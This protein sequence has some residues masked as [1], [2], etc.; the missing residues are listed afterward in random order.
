MNFKWKIII[1]SLSRNIYFLPKVINARMLDHLLYLIKIRLA[2]I[3]MRF[4][5]YLGDNHGFSRHMS[6]GY[7]YLYQLF[8]GRLCVN[9]YIEFN[10][11]N[12]I[13]ITNN[14]YSDVSISNTIF[15]LCGREDCLSV[16]YCL[17][18]YLQL[19]NIICH[20]IKLCIRYIIN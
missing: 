10:F 15:F 3:Q 7:D 11:D 19:I 4:P 9:D 18:N 16:Q 17:C 2:G 8:K 12:Y 14:C 6:V 20:P 1:S 13:D 5:C